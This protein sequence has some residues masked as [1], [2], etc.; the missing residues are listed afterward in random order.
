LE[1]SLLTLIICIVIELVRQI[2]F[3]RAFGIIEKKLGDLLDRKLG[4]KKDY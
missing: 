4:S 3:N 1:I 2:F